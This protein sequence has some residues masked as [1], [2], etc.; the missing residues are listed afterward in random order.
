MAPS[1][2]TAM[3][4]YIPLVLPLALSFDSF[5]CSYPLALQSTLN[6]LA[7]V[8]SGPDRGLFCRPLK[9]TGPYSPAPPDRSLVWLQ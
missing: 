6:R 3:C 4:L 8:R 7:T 2:S 9:K 5:V 1:E